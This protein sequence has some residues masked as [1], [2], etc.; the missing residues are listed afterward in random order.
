MGPP[1][2]QIFMTFVPQ[3]VKTESR[4]RLEAHML[5][6][7][8]IRKVCRNWLKCFPKFILNKTHSKVLLALQVGKHAC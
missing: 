5:I 1:R 8:G 4:L 3:R 7:H 6:T 2:L